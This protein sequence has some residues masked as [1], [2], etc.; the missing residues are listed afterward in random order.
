M[1]IKLILVSAI[2]VVLV[3]LPFVL[4]PFIQKNDAKKLGQKFR[5]EE[6]NHN[7]N[8]GLNEE[9]NQNA[10]GIDPDQQK[11]LFVQ[12]TEDGF[13]VEC[14]DL[15]LVLTCIPIIDEITVV[16]NGKKE[17]HLKSIHF[18]LTFRKN[19]EKK[20]IVLFDYDLHVSQDLEI[21]HA[22]KWAA[23]IKQHLS[24][25]PVYSRTA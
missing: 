11:L 1:D 2:L 10:I 21:K 18:A 3:I 19:D 20:T 14:V 6:K 15:K 23:L 9:W 4:L 8:I 22:Q 25:Q 16:K 13:M 17:T 5:K 24:N 7:L 12:K